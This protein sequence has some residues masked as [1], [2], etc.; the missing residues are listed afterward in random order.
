MEFQKAVHPLLT[1]SKS[2]NS[3]QHHLL[4]HPPH[5]TL[6]LGL[7]NRQSGDLR[8]AKG[9]PPAQRERETLSPA[10]GHN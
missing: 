1:A 5:L 9:R 8:T 4:P 6:H 7:Q 10:S 3:Q 2:T